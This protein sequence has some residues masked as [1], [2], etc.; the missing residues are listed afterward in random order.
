MPS[1][2]EGQPKPINDVVTGLVHEFLEMLGDGEAGC[3]PI[4]IVL[5]SIVVGP[6]STGWFVCPMQVQM[7]RLKS[8]LCRCLRI[9]WF[10]A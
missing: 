2:E 9:N 7:K 4:S 10:G 6:L 8:L 3:H 1:K 5:F